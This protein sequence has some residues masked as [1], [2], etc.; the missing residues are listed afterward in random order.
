MSIVM[1]IP[2]VRYMKLYFLI[3][4]DNE[5]IGTWREE[6]LVFCFVELKEWRNQQIEKLL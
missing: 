3:I 4:N 5:S 6:D 2:K 1:T